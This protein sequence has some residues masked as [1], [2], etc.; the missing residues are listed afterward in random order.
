MNLIILRRIRDLLPGNEH[1]GNLLHTQS[2][3]SK[4]E[5]YLGYML[6]NTPALERVSA[7]S[8]FRE[9]TV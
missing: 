8:L 3:F 5:K 6:T 7:L 2:N 9:Y 1:A 4:D